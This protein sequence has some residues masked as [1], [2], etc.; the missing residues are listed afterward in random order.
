MAPQRPAR[1]IDVANAHVRSAHVKDTFLQSALES[2]RVAI[3]YKI[4]FAG[5]KREWHRGF[6]SAFIRLT[7]PFGIS[8]KQSVFSPQWIIPASKSPVF[9]QAV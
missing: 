6:I 3:K 5:D 9:A 1:C 8:L 4:D 2:R 7:N